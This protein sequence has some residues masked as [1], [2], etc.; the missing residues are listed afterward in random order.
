MKISVVGA[1]NVGAGVVQKIAGND[2]AD[3][4]V[5]IDIVEGLPQGKAL[6]MMESSPVEGFSGKIVGTNSYEPATASDIV[7]I[8]SGL[9]RKPG[10]SRDD[11]QAFNADVVKSVTESIVKVAPDSIII[12]VTNPLDVMAYVALKVSKFVPHR[13]M[14]MAG[15]LDTSRFRYFIAEEL[16]V[17]I[18]DVTAF[19]LGGH[20]DDMV[21]LPRF[22]T[23]AGIPIPQLLSKEAIDRLVDRTRNG[24]IEI[25]NY[26]K[27]GSAYYAPASSVAQMVESIVKNK[28][29]ILPC[30]AWLT[31][32]YG[33]RDLFVG[34]PVKLSSKGIEQVIE[35]EL[36]PEEQEALHASAEHVRQNVAK[37]KI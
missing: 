15:I 18:D 12:M 20:G 34:V 8:T 37:L 19:V 24:G 17:S 22:S 28:K 14:G 33:I 36:T 2:L 23:V 9:A 21:P 30:A 1:G 11:L 3:E 26:L 29:R 25:V 10:M 27:T 6:D 13:V 7:V 16:D 35:I 32:Q 4:I 31:G 5:M